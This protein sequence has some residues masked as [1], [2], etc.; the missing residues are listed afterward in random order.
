ME[1]RFLEHALYLCDWEHRAAYLWSLNKQNTSLYQSHGFE[2]VTTIQVG[3]SP[4]I[5]PMLRRPR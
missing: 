5:F 1:R 4:P 2:V 3:P